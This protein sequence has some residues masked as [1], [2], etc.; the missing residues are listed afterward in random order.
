MRVGHA[1]VLLASSFLCLAPGV[2]GETGQEGWLRYAALPPQLAQ[3][4]KI[5]HRIVAASQSVVAQSAAGE[6]A[7]GLHSML[8]AN[9]MVSS[10]SAG[11]DAFLL[12]T[13]AEVQRMLP[14]WKPESPIAP[15]GFSLAQ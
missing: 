14:A 11:N 4:Y 2:Y 3:H 7:R 6:F 12:G 1:V 10:T 8:G 13:A 15:E 5:P 9:F